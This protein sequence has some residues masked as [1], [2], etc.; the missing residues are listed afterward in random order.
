MALSWDRALAQYVLALTSGDDLRGPIRVL[1]EVSSTCDDA[2]A[3]A[4]LNAAVGSALLLG[5]ESDD[6]AAAA[7]CVA[8]RLIIRSIDAASAVENQP[9]GRF[10]DTR[11]LQR[12]WRELYRRFF[13]AEELLAGRGLRAISFADVGGTAAA[14][15]MRHQTRRGR[16]VE[17]CE[18]FAQSFSRTTVETAAVV[19]AL[20]AGG[21]DHSA[22]E[23][24]AKLPVEARSEVE[25]GALLK[26]VL[27]KE[28]LRRSGDW[29]SLSPN[30]D[31]L[32]ARAIR[33]FNETVVV[34]STAEI[35]NTQ[36]VVGMSDSQTTL[37]NHAIGILAA[38]N[39]WLE[40]AAL[41]AHVAGS[42]A[43][44]P[45]AQSRPCGNGVTVT[46]LC[47]A[48]RSQ[49]HL[50]LHYTSLLL[51]RSAVTNSLDRIA[52]TQMAITCAVSSRWEEATKVCSI[53][54]AR[55]VTLDPVVYCRVI[56]VC[57]ERRQNDV[58]AKLLRYLHKCNNHDATGRALNSMLQHA[59]SITAVQS[60]L[61][62][63][64]HRKLP[65]EFESYEAVVH[66][67]SRDDRWIDALR[68]LSRMHEAETM[69]P[70]A[71]SFEFV[72]VAMHRRRAPWHIALSTFNTMEALGVK[73]SSTIA[74]KA[75][76][77]TCLE[78]GA[79]DI[80]HA[81]FMRQMRRGIGVL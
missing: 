77:G 53:A 54:D 80:A 62:A 9:Q 50:A 19:T 3:R 65:L 45:Q 75:V 5:A 44:G 25:V 58:A 7:S 35:V 64:Q 8:T 52:L 57:N 32:W 1:E 18:F 24:L 40:S 78:H 76:V 2:D 74:F 22:A 34:G 42:V 81:L 17:A 36:R 33:L 63:I 68:Y 28:R 21:Q 69:T 48:L 6:I 67:M 66:H 70:S 31:L 61:D 47:Y 56:E 23:V 12:D 13:S 55:N 11:A 46:M 14:S 43:A 59:Q 41:M 10:Q 29:S 37:V 73:S 15:I 20:L 71:K 51:E 30:D 4:R 49:W 38:R 72:L 39:R 60:W 16:W 27:K 26:S 79:K